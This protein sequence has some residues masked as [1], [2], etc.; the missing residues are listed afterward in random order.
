MLR[1]RLLGS[2]ELRGPGDRPI[3]V[4]ARKT[5]ALLAFLALQDGTRQSR[6]RLAAL[7]WE[8]ADAE[9]ARS[10]LRQALASLRRALPAKLQSLLET[11][12]QQ[13][14]LNLAQLQVDVHGLRALLAEA[15]VPSL[16]AVR[17]IA[18][19]TLLEGF[20]ARS[21]AFE[22]WVAAERR[23]LRRDTAAG[24]TRLAALCREAGDA[25][26]EIDALAWLLAIEPLAE[27]AHRELMGCFA[28]AGRYTEAL[29]QYQLLRTLLRRELDL[30]PDPATEALYRD[31]MKKRRAGASG[32]LYA[33]PGTE[34]EDIVAAE[35][36]A[37]SAAA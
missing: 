13:V 20:D 8:D 2:F 3:T 23:T 5:R 1:L 19:A 7:L 21:G 22:E 35:L 16:R 17:A 14:A 30:A 37:E 33:L 27:G 6:E 15:T 18:G 4:T 31:L 9:L 26:G 10:S 34:P 29:R 11:D 32:P 24:A 12:A 25:D 36:A 28:R